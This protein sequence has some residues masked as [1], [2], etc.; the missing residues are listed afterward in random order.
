MQQAELAQPTMGRTVSLDQMGAE[1][2][3]AMGEGDFPRA[4]AAS[5][6]VLAARPPAERDDAG[7]P[8]HLRWVWDGSA[9]AGQGVLVRCY[10]GLGDTLQFCRFLPALRRRAARVTLEVQPALI[11]LMRLLGAADR[12]VAFD[13]A[14]P[15]PPDSCDIEIMELCHALRLAPE[16][17]PYLE[18]PKDGQDS[19]SG[20]RVGLCWQAQ[21]GWR[22]D[23][24]MPRAALD[25]LP[26]R[27]VRWQSL[28]KGAAADGMAPC[29]SAVLDTARVIAGLDLVV[30][31]DTM[32]AHLA[33]AIGVPVWLLLDASPDWRWLAGG[34]EGSPWYR[35]IRKYRQ[36]APG[37]WGP[38]LREIAADLTRSI[39]AGTVAV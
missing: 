13:P 32:V 7:Q 35:G 38:P 22:P 11:P 28:Q 31:V 19:G 8:Y 39:R 1:W 15:R 2:F 25:V 12:I 17:L 16:P 27:G 34:R 37:D 6:C 36:T 5:D 33:G 10:H 4:W 18:I 14:A 23:R 20:L 24:S 26:W 9:L 29:P 30:T 3:A 21:A